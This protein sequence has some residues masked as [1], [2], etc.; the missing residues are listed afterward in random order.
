[1]NQELL[2]EKQALYLQ[3][4]EE[5]YPNLEIH[6]AR[7]HTNEGQFNDILFINEVLVF[8]FPRYEGDIPAFIQEIKVL[9]SLQGH[10]PLPIP[11]PIYAS[12]HAQE[13][14]RVFMG[15]KILPGR[16][17]FRSLLQN[18]TDE[19]VLDSFSRQIANFLH[20]LHKLSPAQIGWELTTTDEL[21]KARELFSKIERHL[22]QFMRPEARESVTRHFE[23]YFDRADLHQYEL[24]VIH[25]DFGGSN[26]LFEENK[27]TGIID[28]S[29]AGPGDPAVDIASISTVGES[30]FARFCKQYPLSEA[31]LERARFYRGTY[32]L[33]EAL[34]GF[35]HNDLEAFENGLEQYR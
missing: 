8:R 13:T 12:L 10:L 28:F 27:I 7:L 14:G 21:E 20:E 35:L 4:I 24:S 5:N 26:I 34:Y 6:S 32:A 18:I 31:L 9:Q 19:K 22:F 29:S 30:F 17:L 11:D 25:G 15:Y 33:Q 3:A 16:P 1:M 23:N 2:M